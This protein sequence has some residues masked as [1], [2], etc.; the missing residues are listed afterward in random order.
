MNKKNSIDVISLLGENFTLLLYRESK[1]SC[2]LL[3]K[4]IL[5]NVKPK[6]H[7]ILAFTHIKDLI[8]DE[9]V[10]IDITI[11][12]GR[13]YTLDLKYYYKIKRNLES[14]SS[15]VDKEIESLNNTI[16]QRK[17]S[18]PI[19]WAYVYYYL[20]KMENYT[21]EPIKERFYDTIANKHGFDRANFKKA[22]LSFNHAEKG[23]N[24][25]TSAKLYDILLEATKEKALYSHPKSL[26]LAQQDLSIIEQ[27]R[28]NK[29]D[30]KNI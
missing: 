7:K 21:I 8:V 3:L 11:D 30:K 4:S 6:E 29:A 24:N 27:K 10:S 17:A 5:K 15:S 2:D 13:D 18:E 12:S 16:P 25:R 20:M 1:S 22:W 14:L 26:A 23:K 9:L 19:I 28:K